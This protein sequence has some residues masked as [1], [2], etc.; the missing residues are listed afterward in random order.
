MPYTRTRLVVDIPPEDY[1][2]LSKIL[3]HGE[4]K[5]L[6]TE[7]VKSLLS[8]YDKFGKVVFYSIMSGSSDFLKVATKQM[9]EADGDNNGSK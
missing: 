6:F 5:R 9:E 1:E 8:A 3:E 7:V 2:R 4:S